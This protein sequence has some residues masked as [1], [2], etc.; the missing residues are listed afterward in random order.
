M[1]VMSCMYALWDLL[2]HKISDKT[3][4]FDMKEFPTICDCWPWPGMLIGLQSEH[5]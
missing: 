2:E 4:E 1:G 3:D 5:F